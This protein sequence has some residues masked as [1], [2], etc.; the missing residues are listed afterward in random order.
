MTSPSLDSDGKMIKTD[1]LVSG[2]VRN[3]MNEYNY[4]VEIPEEIIS[5]VFLF[6]FIQ[7]CDE[8]DGSLSHDRFVEIDGST[9]KVRNRFGTCSMFGTKVIET[10]TFKWSLKFKTDINWSCIGICIDTKEELEKSKRDN[11]YGRDVGCGCFWFGGRGSLCWDDQEMW[12]YSGAWHKA[13]TKI[14]MTLNMDD[15]TIQYK[16]NGINYKTVKIDSLSKEIGYRLAVTVSKE[17]N[18][19]ELL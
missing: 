9:A 14:E 15:Q 5:L 7:I 19:I 12:L 18:A 13:G 8:W 2:Y 10:G 1:I 16:I 6:W 11:Y 17:G 4:K 3:A